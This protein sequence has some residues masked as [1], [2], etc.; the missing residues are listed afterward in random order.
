MKKI[1]IFVFCLFAAAGCSKKSDDIKVIRQGEQNPDN[2]TG[3][4]NNSDET[5]NKLNGTT[6]KLNDANNKGAGEEESDVSFGKSKSEK[7][8]AVEITSKEAGAHTGDFAKIKGYVAD[9]NVREKVAYLNF[10][11]KYPKHSFT[12]VVFKDKFD[13]FG[14][15]NRFRNKN[16]EVEG[17]ITEYNNKPQVILN[18]VKQ[19]RIVN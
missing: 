2:K 15:L 14:D 5:A 4:V 12:A 11:N 10:D 7:K 16:V 13:A 18:S 17:K 6:D 3:A 1:L 9:V 19:I 8:S